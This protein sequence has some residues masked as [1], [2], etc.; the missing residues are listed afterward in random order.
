MGTYSCHPLPRF[1]RRGSVDPVHRSHPCDSRILC[2]PFLS[3]PFFKPS[4]N[5]TI[6]NLSCTSPYGSP[7]LNPYLSAKPCPS[8][9]LFPPLVHLPIFPFQNCHRPLLPYPPSLPIFALCLSSR[10]PTPPS[11]SPVSL[12]GDPSLPCALSLLPSP[13]GLGTGSYPRPQPVTSRP[14]S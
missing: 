3:V 11:S 5:R 2:R 13:P 14:L 4:L 1:Y 6:L 10:I 8:F 12:G 7:V 9:S